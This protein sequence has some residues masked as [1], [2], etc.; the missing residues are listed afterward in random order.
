MGSVVSGRVYAWP[1][2]RVIVA[3]VLVLAVP[4]AA[5]A[6]ALPV[7]QGVVTD[8]VTDDQLEGVWIDAFYEVGVG[9]WEYV[10]WTV[11]DPTGAF[12]I[13]D[14]GR[15]AGRYRLDI[16]GL[17]YYPVTVI[18]EWDGVTPLVLD[19]A[20]EP[21]VFIAQG[22]VTDAQTA[23]RILGARV[24][25]FY[26]DPLTQE[27]LWAG[28]GDSD[29]DGFYHLIDWE[30]Y[31]PGTY[32]IRVG[33]GAEYV[34]QAVTRAW[35]GGTPVGQDFQLAVVPS[36]TSIEGADR[37][38]TAIAASRRAFPTTAETVLIATGRN[39]PDALGGAALAG[40][41]RGPI[42]LVDT[43]SVPA[44]VTSE[45]KRLD[46]RQAIILGGTQAVGPEVEVALRDLLGEDN[47]DRLAG[48]DRYE[49]AEVIAAQVLEFMPPSWGFVATGANFPDALA[50]APLAAMYAYPLFLAHPVTGLSAA[51]EAAMQNLTHV[52][53]LGGP[54]VVSSETY[55][56]L[57]S[58]HGSSNVVRLGGLNR[59][60]TAVEV[61]EHAS[62][63]WGVRW[64]FVG[65]ATGENFPDALAGGVLQG[66]MFSQM[67]LTQSSSLSP[68][69]AAALEARSAQIG[70]VTFYGGTK[71]VSQAVRTSVVALIE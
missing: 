37:Y 54:S 13:A 2:L 19:V 15:G 42:L 8:A 59:Y 23:S 31:G 58:V 3:C 50:A 69:T 46:A 47:V 25:A 38:L 18:G 57:V 35:D 28:S 32:E 4:T 49:T 61:A 41:V 68:D 1:V 5:W 48:E 14:E 7:V 20:L 34:G 30:G 24:V 43:H 44:A 29:D 62:A 10:A 16:Y 53:V 40:A 64:D 55:D 36:V 26:L 33:Y 9:E 63:K 45:I 67:L 39:W 60:A 56:Y 12:T 71:A 65:V 17:G 22:R 52:M 11:S 6:V 27:W 66:A 21:F 51:T 70:H